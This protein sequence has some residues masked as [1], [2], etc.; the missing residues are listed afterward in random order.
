[1][2]IE[3]L[4]KKCEKLQR[5]YNDQVERANKFNALLAR[6]EKLNENQKDKDQN[7]DQ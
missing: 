7:E 1:M 3:I 2:K 4:S 5:N 6:F